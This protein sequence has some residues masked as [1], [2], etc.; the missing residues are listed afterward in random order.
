MWADSPA[1]RPARARV[2]S[3]GTAALMGAAVRARCGGTPANLIEVFI[4]PS[5]ENK[6]ARLTGDPMEPVFPKRVNAGRR[7]T[8]GFHPAGFWAEK[9][10]NRGP[11]TV[12][13]CGPAG[14]RSRTGRGPGGVHRQPVVIWPVVR[15]R[16][17]VGKNSLRKSVAVPKKGRVRG[18]VA[19]A[20]RRKSCPPPLD[21][22]AHWGG[23]ECVL[24]ARAALPFAEGGSF[25]RTRPIVE[26]G[27]AGT[28]S[29]RFRCVKPGVWP[30]REK[31]SPGP[32]REFQ[33]A[34]GLL[35][36]GGVPA[37][38]SMAHNREI[39]PT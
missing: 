25:R 13:A 36:Q 32:L 6:F 30:K 9:T 28:S 38:Q 24:G 22:A 29:E 18:L 1:C 17:G 7:R 5:P 26:Q 16:S 12:V 3:Y 23:P 11:A 15:C 19:A 37:V 4:W 10:P 34:L 2:V 31:G 33:A 35:R 14:V 8:F 27:R 21:Q 39:E 20:T